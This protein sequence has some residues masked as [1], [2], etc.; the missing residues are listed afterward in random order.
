MHVALFI[1]VV[2]CLRRQCAHLGL[3]ATATFKKGD[4]IAPY[5]GDVVVTDDPDFGDD[6]TLKIAD[7]PAQCETAR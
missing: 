7:D 6:Y 4:T 3:Y 5:D 1:P 2:K